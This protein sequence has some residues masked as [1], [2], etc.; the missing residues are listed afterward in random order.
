MY[1][2]IL[3]ILALFGLAISTIYCFIIYPRPSSGKLG[4]W[5]TEANLPVIGQNKHYDFILLGTSHARIFSRYHNHARVEKLLDKKFINLAQGG[6]RG[7]VVN[8][9]AY[10]RYFYQKNNSASTLVYVI[11]PFIFYRDS[12]DNTP[13]IYQ[14]EPFDKDFLRI[15][16]QISKNKEVIDS[17]KKN[18]VT[19]PRQ[20]REYNVY[21]KLFQDD[22]TSPPTD[23]EI[24]DRVDFLYHDPFEEEK[25]KERF[26]T[27][28]ESIQI[29]RQHNTKVIV[30]V[31]TTLLKKQPKDEY[32][33]EMIR[34]NAG[35]NEY[36]YYNLWNAVSDT[37]LYYD[38]DHLN[39]EGILFFTAKYL[40]PL[41][42]E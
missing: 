23:Q 30:L 6:E 1:K 25:F 17:Y 32:I 26:A 42:E 8:Q 33:L 9:Q 22:K 21:Q 14:F 20:P 5:Q 29:A 7:G 12:L 24:K 28:Q 13:E 37:N 35:N 31:P 38:T 19:P 4:N 41:L 40:K 34:K 27:M 3:F 18:S 10:L 2:N 15:L 39:T 11:D 36:Q 16:E